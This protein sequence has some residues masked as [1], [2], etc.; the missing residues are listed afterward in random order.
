MMLISIYI[1]F[2]K[3]IIVLRLISFLLFL[4]ELKYTRFKKKNYKNMTIAIAI[5]F[6]FTGYSIFLAFK[7]Q[8]IEKRKFSLY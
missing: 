6:G 2:L 1:Y 4:Y 8:L 3:S 7:R 5:L